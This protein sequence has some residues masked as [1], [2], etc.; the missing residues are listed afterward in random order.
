MLICNG[1]TIES[2]DD[3]IAQRIIDYFPPVQRNRGIKQYLTTL[4]DDDRAH[5]FTRDIRIIEQY[6]RQ[7]GE[8]VRNNRALM[9]RDPDQAEEM[10]SALP[11]QE[12][13]N[14]HERNEEQEWQREYELHYGRDRDRDRPL[15]KSRLDDAC[16]RRFV[17]TMQ[18]SRRR[19]FADC[20]RKAR[21]DA[22]YR[23]RLNVTWHH[24][25]NV[26]P[27]IAGGE[28]I[29]TCDMYL[30]YRNHHAGRGLSHSGGCA[31]YRKYTGRKY[32]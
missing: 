18:G 1:H 25:E 27:H 19:D 15:D 16:K 17:I 7:I 8:E 24:G 11:A 20:D 13:L 12:K 6:L 31:E 21:I 30:I 3:H 29:F 10:P 4:I 2:L 23:R 14:E 32:R 22:A 26:I 5:R 28:V 9:L